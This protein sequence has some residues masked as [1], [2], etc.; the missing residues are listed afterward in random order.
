MRKTTPW[1]RGGAESGC[2][3]EGRE[4]IRVPESRGDADGRRRAKSLVAQRGITAAPSP[5][6]CRASP[7]DREMLCL[8]R[9]GG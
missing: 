7:Y 8:S 6:P 9:R 2:D 5:T 4:D 3:K 1:E